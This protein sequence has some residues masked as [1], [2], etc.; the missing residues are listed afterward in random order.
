[1]VGE[2]ASASGQVSCGSLGRGE[3][4]R[5][6][7]HRDQTLT[8]VDGKCVQHEGFGIRLPTQRRAV[9]LK[10]ETVEEGELGTTC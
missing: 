6:L 9:W 1:M 2:S 7:G 4:D 8:V 3:F 5:A 10:G